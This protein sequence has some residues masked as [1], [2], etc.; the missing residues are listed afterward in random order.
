MQRLYGRTVSRSLGRLK[1][2]ALIHGRPWRKYLLIN[3]ALEF[4][5]IDCVLALVAFFFGDSTHAIVIC[6]VCFGVRVAQAALA[7]TFVDENTG[8]LSL[9]LILLS[10]VLYAVGLAVAVFSPMLAIV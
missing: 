7:L 9:T 8:N 10:E 5:L 4:A 3:V 6:S 2:Q 1:V